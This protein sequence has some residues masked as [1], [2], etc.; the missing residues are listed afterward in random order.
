MEITSTRAPN[1]RGLGKIAFFNRS[2]ILPLIRL[3]V[4]S[5]CPSIMVV[6]VDDGA[7]DI[8][9]VSSTMLVAV[10]SVYHTYGSL[11]RYS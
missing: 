4:D 6:R 2:R 3:N 7:L 11:Q 9:A 1:A 10:K 8:Y 5:Q